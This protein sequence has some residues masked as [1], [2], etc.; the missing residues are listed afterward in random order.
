[1]H[2][3]IFQ[4]DFIDHSDILPQFSNAK[5]TANKCN[6]STIMATKME[7][8]KIFK[9]G[10]STIMFKNREISFPLITPWRLVNKGEDVEI[11]YVRKNIQKQ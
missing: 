9:R 10:K 8:S 1:M 3:E 6:N 4:V 5:V 11:K 7:H 2:D